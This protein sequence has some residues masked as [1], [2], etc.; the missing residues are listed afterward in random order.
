MDD[1]KFVSYSNND[2]VASRINVGSE[3]GSCLVDALSS[4][5][6]GQV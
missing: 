3:W 5:D 6:S 1:L 4:V 2:L